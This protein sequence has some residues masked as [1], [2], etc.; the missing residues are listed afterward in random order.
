MDRIEKQEL[1][2]AHREYAKLAEYLNGKGFVLGST[3]GA[4]PP[5]FI[6]DDDDSPYIVEWTADGKWEV[7]D[8]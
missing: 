5:Y 2:A 8:Y 1:L 7:A 4:Y 3:D 6:S